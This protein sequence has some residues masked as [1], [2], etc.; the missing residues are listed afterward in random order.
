MIEVIKMGEKI[1]YC[2]N[3]KCRKKLEGVIAN[4]VTDLS[5]DTFDLLI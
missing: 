1:N 2:N 3:L 4:D 5:I